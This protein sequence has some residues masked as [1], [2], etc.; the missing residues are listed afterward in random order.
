MTLLDFVSHSQS[1]VQVNQGKCLNS[2]SMWKKSRNDLK[3]NVFLNISHTLQCVWCLNQQTLF[4]AGQF[5]AG[6]CTHPL[7]TPPTLVWLQ[8]NMSVQHKFIQ[9]Y[10]MWTLRLVNF[11]TNI[12]WMKNFSI[13]PELEW[14]FYIKYWIYE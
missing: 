14:F 8:W 6:L 12:Q 2:S 5:V 9:K 3:C 1:L 11:I 7:F 4:L 13:K 10:C